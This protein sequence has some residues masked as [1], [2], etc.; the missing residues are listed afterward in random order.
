[1]RISLALPAL[2]TLPALP[3]LPKLTPFPD[4]PP[5]LPLKFRHVHRLYVTLATC[6][7]IFL[8][9]LCVLLWGD[10]NS[11]LLV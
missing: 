9:Y 1:M 6:I 10:R 3:T 7:Y 11:T 8:S 4:L 2:T 5:L